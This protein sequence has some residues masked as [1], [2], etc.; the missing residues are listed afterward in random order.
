VVRVSTLGRD[1]RA[2]NDSCGGASAYK[3]ARSRRNG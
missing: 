1:E 2:R 3:H